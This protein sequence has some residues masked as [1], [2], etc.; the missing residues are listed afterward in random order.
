MSDDEIEALRQRRLHELQQQVASQQEQSVKAAEAEERIESVLR[1][2]LTP[3]AKARL[4]NVRLASQEKYMTVVSALVQLFQAGQLRGKV[5][6]EQL[7]G[8]LQRKTGP[9]KEFNIQKPGKRGD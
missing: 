9:R 1:R 6:D 2:I 7:K 5:T 8:L 4:A 3:E